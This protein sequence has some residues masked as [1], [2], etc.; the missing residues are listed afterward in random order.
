MKKDL[1][2]F[3]NLLIYAFNVDVIE[4]QFYHDIMCLTAPA[5]LSS[6]DCNMLTKVLPFEKWQYIY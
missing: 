6:V 5:Y 2:E 3:S 1:P 4:V